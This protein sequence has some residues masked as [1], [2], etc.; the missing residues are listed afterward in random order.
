MKKH[1]AHLLADA[2]TSGHYTRTG[3][4]NRRVDP[5]TKA[6]SFCIGGVLINLFAQAHPE[7]AAKETDPFTF[8]ACSSSIPLAVVSWA[9][10]HSSFMD[11]INGSITINDHSFGGLQ[12]ANDEKTNGKP[13]DPYT[14]SWDDIAAWLRSGENYKL[15]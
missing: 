3:G 4:T 15:V 2:I 8:M 14:V 5:K 13:T 9:G 12:S 10:L 6:N 7:L 1:I 11:A